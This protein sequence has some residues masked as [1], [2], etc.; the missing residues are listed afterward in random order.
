MEKNDL[1]DVI[2]SHIRE[3]E[4]VRVPAR[5]GNRKKMDIGKTGLETQC[6][7]LCTKYHKYN[8]YY[9]ES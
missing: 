4:S 2:L 9:I 3:R 6:T 1:G 7:Y 8:I 5:Q